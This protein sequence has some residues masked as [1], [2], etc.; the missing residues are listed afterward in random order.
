M[1]VFGRKEGET[2]DIAGG[3]ENGGIT[4]T[5]VRIK[6]NKILI[7]VDAPRDITIHRGEIQSRIDGDDE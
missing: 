5:L 1:L 4:V 7:G 2:V 6:G 3:F